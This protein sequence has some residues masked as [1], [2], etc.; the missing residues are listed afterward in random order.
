MKLQT[1]IVA[2]DTGLAWFAQGQRV[3]QWPYP[4]WGL[5]AADEVPI[6]LTLMDVSTIYPIPRRMLEVGPIVDMTLCVHEGIRMALPLPL[7]AVGESAGET[8]LLQA[9]ELMHM[10]RS[11][12]VYYKQVESLVRDAVWEFRTTIS[13]LTLQ[14]DL[15]RRGQS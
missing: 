2:I 7:T 12:N 5:C 1:Y 14:L 13:K 9:L 6:M 8:K 11:E 15:A 10:H 3:Y 4:D